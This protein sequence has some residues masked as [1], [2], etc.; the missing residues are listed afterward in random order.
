MS[1]EVPRAERIARDEL[2]PAD[3]V[4]FGARGPASTPS[5][6]DHMG[7]YVGNGWFIN[8]SGQGVAVA[9]LT[10]WNRTHFAWGRPDG[11][12]EASGH[13][14]ALWSVDTS[15]DRVAFVGEAKGMWLW[16]VLW[17]ASAGVLLLEDIG[18]ADA[19]DFGPAAYELLGYGAESPRL[20]PPPVGSVS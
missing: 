6:V 5:E 17:P 18:L 13:P 20:D 7:I 2:Q 1:G 15:D 12:V 16:A 8:S 9:Q 14:T 3:L 10:G 4:F 19:R 11:K